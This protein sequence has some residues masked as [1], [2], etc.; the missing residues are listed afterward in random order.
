[1]LPVWHIE[2]HRGSIQKLLIGFSDSR[3]YSDAVALLEM[4][5]AH[6]NQI[7]TTRSKALGDGLFEL[8]GKQVRIFYIFRPGRRIVVLE[9]MVKKRTKIPSDVV[10]R[11]RK[12]AREVS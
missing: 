4:L 10:D 6:G 1:V 3:D 11:M 7:A 8:R 5:T 2:E 9:G 12:L